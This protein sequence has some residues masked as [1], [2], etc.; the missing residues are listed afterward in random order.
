MAQPCRQFHVHTSGVPG[1]DF[2]LVV[3]SF[4]KQVTDNAAHHRSII[5]ASVRMCQ[6]HSTDPSVQM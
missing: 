4:V 5:T 1:Q 2:D 3:Q 6:S